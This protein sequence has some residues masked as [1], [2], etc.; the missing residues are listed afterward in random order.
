[1]STSSISPLTHYL[2]PVL[3]PVL[4]ATGSTTSATGSTIS[5]IPADTTQI[6]PLASLLSQLQK[7]Q[8]SDPA[9]YQQLTQQIATNLQN[10]AQT[11]QTEGNSTAANQ[12]N[13]LAAD[14]TSA[15]QTGQLPNIQDLGQAIGGGHH[16][17]HH[18]HASSSADS[19]S[20]TNSTSTTASSTSS[21]DTSLL[22]NQYQ[23]AYP[24]GQQNPLN[25]ILNTLSS[26]GI[27]DS[28]S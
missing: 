27:S 26:A 28:N 14:F 18:A 16:H 10:A 5:T 7:I 21:L 19:D 3:N 6:S 24:T 4:T 9:Q 25:I 2:Q 11:A 13:T 20:S 17:H 22:V 23:S 8:Q 12:L 1:M 15:S